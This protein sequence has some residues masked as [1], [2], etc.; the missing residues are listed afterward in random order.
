MA[1]LKARLRQPKILGPAM[2]ATAAIAEADPITSVALGRAGVVPAVVA[3]ITI[4][5]TGLRTASMLR[6]GLGSCL[7]LYVL[8]FH[9]SLLPTLFM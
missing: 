2:L 5:A 8:Q 6:D 4:A 9:C 3:V 7:L 1:V